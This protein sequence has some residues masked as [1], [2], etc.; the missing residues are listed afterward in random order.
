MNLFGWLIDRRIAAFQNELLEKHV[1]EV[2]N[3][4]RQMR[5]WKHDYHNHI[6]TMK[7]L[8]DGVNPAL[9]TYLNNLDADLTAVDT[10]LKTGNVM[11]DAIVNSKLSLAARRGIEA[12]AKAFVPKDMPIADID[13]CVI[14]GNLLDNAMEA[15]AQAEE[16]GRWVRLYIDVMGEELYLS[17]SNATNGQ[18]RRVGGSYASTKGG[19]HGFGLLRVDRLVEKYSGYLNRQHEEGIFATEVLLPLTDRSH[20]ISDH[21]PQK[22]PRA[23]TS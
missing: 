2:E 14:L 22:T 10:I 19:T 17:I 6:Q 21:S 8:S 4:Y 12:N 13:L 18:R 5:G 9:D 7:A 23:H 1:S 15:C 16:G 20:V 11:V 3:I